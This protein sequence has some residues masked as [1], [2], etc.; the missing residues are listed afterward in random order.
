MFIISDTQTMSMKGVRWCFNKKVV[1]DDT[2]IN[3]FK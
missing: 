3:F 2:E 1:S